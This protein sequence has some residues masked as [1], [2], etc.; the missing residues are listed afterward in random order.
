VNDV[1]IM[2]EPTNNLVGYFADWDT[3]KDAEIPPLEYQDIIRSVD[4]VYN[5]I[6]EN[7][8]DFGTHSDDGNVLII[9]DIPLTN[10]NDIQS[11]VYYNRSGEDRSIGLVLELYNITND[12]DFV[13]PLATSNII[14]TYELRYRFDFPSITSYGLGFAT[15]NSTSQIVN[16]SIALTETIIV[17]N[18]EMTGNVS[19]NNDLSVGGS[20]F[21]GDTNL[22]EDIDGLLTLDT[23]K[24][25]TI[26]GLTSGFVTSGEVNC[27]NLN[28]YTQGNFGI[29]DSGNDLT[30]SGT[31]IN[32]NSDS[33][34][35]NSAGGNS[36]NH[37]VIFV[38][39][40]EYKIKLENAS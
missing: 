24:R 28:V 34:I 5:N 38:N 37:L 39:G 15:E 30:L 7:N 10:I 22:T 27:D 4:K 25:L 32:F 14:S 12:A 33:F 31:Q 16:D 9:K 23:N 20:L 40:T 26:N 1:N 18:I 3:D 19:M 35:S 36:G 17:S 21:L 2:V 13:Y 11:I 29:P 6:L 8:N